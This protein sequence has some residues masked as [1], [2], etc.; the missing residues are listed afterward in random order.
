[1][2]A[3][4]FGKVRGS[5]QPNFA[6]GSSQPLSLNSRGE[7]I[8]VQ[9]LPANAQLVSAGSSYMARTTTAT[10]PVT[11]IPTTA[12]LLGLWNGEPD[13][14]KCY[15]VDSFFVV[16]V[17]PTAAVQAMSILANVSTQR[18]DTAI[19]NT[20]APVPLKG[21]RPY[22][23]QGRVAVGITLDATNGVAAN[24]YP[25]GSSGTPVNTT[26]VGQCLD[27][28]VN[29]AIIIPPKGQL[30]LSVLSGAATASSIQVGVRWH[31]VILPPTV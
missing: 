18:V 16:I 1:M 14:G 9:G 8:T 20:I 3:N 29:G 27:V 13:N 28:P 24:W 25:W 23:G 10:A 17:G 15:V 11:A 7:Q 26:Q 31:E 2:D 6:E 22:N 21:N 19:A 12:A 5:Q 4:V 30:S